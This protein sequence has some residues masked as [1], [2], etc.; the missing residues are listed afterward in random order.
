MSE[1][2]RESKKNLS[3]RF[4]VD[5]RTLY[6][7]NVACS[8][9]YNGIVCHSGNELSLNKIY[10]SVALILDNFRDKLEKLQNQKA[11]SL[12][13]DFSEELQNKSIGFEFGKEKQSGNSFYIEH[14]ICTT[15]YEQIE[16]LQKI[17]EAFINKAIEP[18]KSSIKSKFEAAKTE[19]EKTDT[20]TTRP[21]QKDLVK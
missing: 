12:I 15:K 19:S 16:E 8:G 18:D 9:A 3:Y 17:T 5:D 1:K 11:D 7:T 2:N 20:S 10:E 21:V 6:S 13:N 14:K 4:I